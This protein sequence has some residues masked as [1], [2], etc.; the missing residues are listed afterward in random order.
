MN[1]HQTIL[2]LRTKK[3]PM[4]I[5]RLKIEVVPKFQTILRSTIF[6]AMTILKTMN[7]I[8]KMTLVRLIRKNKSAGIMTTYIDVSVSVR[9]SS[10]SKS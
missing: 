1:N 2:R 6:Q 10:S 5:Y 7:K 8:R 9:G 4:M 3:T